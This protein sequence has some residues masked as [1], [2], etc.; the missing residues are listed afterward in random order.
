MVR[1]L[2]SGIVVIGVGGA[3]CNMLAGFAREGYENVELLAVDT[4]VKALKSIS[5]EGIKKLLIGKRVTK[6]LGTGGRPG[7]AH[8]AAAKEEKEISK[9]MGNPTA[10]YLLAG[11]GGGTGTGAI[12][13]LAKI[14]SMKNAIVNA[15]VTYPLDLEKQRA[16]RADLYMPYLMQNCDSVTIENNNALV[17][18]MP[19]SQIREAFKVMDKRVAD[20]IRIGLEEWRA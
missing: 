1:L 9:A 4:D 5:G 13:V 19:N 16:R 10:I 14:A 11:L 12:L 3:G 18:F 2:K 6:G 7:L 15:I 8:T 20:R 17:R